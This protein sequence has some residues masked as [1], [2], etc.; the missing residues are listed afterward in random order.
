MVRVAS[1]ARV[2]VGYVSARRTGLLL[3]LLTSW[4]EAASKTLLKGTTTRQNQTVL[5]VTERT[6]GQ[7]R[8]LPALAAAQVKQ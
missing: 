3:E 6:V 8:E 4:L 7:A 1:D 2:S 5:L